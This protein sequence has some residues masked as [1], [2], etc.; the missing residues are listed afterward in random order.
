MEAISPCKQGYRFD[1]ANVLPVTTELKKS[2]RPKACRASRND[3]FEHFE[4]A[5]LKAALDSASR[6]RT[7]S[8]VKHELGRPNV[9][10]VCGEVNSTMDS[11]FSGTSVITPIYFPPPASTI[12]DI[13]RSLKSG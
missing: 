8:T 11:I 10:L 4:S 13:S 3:H 12:E 5:R 6:S 2:P 7:A 9:D 1:P